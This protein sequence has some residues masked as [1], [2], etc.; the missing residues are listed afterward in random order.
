M[1]KVMLAVAYASVLLGFLVLAAIFFA[2]SARDGAIF[3]WVVGLCVVLIH[4][5]QTGHFWPRA[6]TAPK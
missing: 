1:T 2:D 3:L 6:V 4:W 5:I